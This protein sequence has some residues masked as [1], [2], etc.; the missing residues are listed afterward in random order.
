MVEMTHENVHRLTTEN[1]EHLDRLAG[2]CVGHSAAR[3]YR[4]GVLFILGLVQ[5]FRFTKN[6]KMSDQSKIE[7]LEKRIQFLENE[8]S[9]LK[10]ML[11][12]QIT[13]GHKITV[14]VA[15]MDEL[16]EKK[17]LEI[18]ALNKQL[19]TP[20]STTKIEPLEDFSVD[21]ESEGCQVGFLEIEKWREIRKNES[22][23]ERTKD[24]KFKCPYKDVCNYIAKHRHNLNIHIRKH[25]GE[26]PFICNFCHKD[27]D[28]EDSCRKHMLTHSEMGAVICRYCHKRYLASSI[29]THQ[30]RCLRRKRNR[31]ESESDS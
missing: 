24:R 29:E 17:K 26:R 16:L 15:E 28:R 10:S 18:D 3:D 23:F 11:K 1:Q 19:L 7:N 9:L 5:N 22:E 6:T 27:F 12:Q 25:T 30:K 21:L 20:P 8:N 2:V 4:H 13:F 31:P 14:I